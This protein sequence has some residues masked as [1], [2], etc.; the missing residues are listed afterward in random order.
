MDLGVGFGAARAPRACEV[1]TG[2]SETK[3]YPKIHEKGEIR[4]DLGSEATFPPSLRGDDREGSER[5]KF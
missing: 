2:P 5:T 1:M 4:K 3:Y